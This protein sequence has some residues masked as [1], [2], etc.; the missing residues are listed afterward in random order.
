MQFPTPTFYRHH[1]RS[2]AQGA[3]RRLRARAAHDDGD[4][5]DDD[6]DFVF[7]CRWI[8]DHRHSKY[9]EALEK[10]VQI[11]TEFCRRLIYL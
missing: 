5:D 8:G 6:D 3:D 7:T 1:C 11:C 4:D 9:A 2:E 10:G